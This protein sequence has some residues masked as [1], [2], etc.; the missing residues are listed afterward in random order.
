MS[1]E[2]QPDFNPKRRM[3]GPQF[4]AHTTSE[5]V[6]RVTYVEED[7]APTAAAPAPVEEAE[8]PPT[9]EVDEQPEQDQ[10][11]SARHRGGRRSSNDFLEGR[12]ASAPAPT[13]TT[14]WRVKANRWSGGLLKLSESTVE[15]QAQEDRR[16]IQRNFGGP[17]SVVTINTKGGVGKTSSTLMTAMTFGMIRGGGVVAWDNNETQGSLGHRGLEGSRDTTAR[18]LL[19]EIHRFADVETSRVGDLG[20]YLRSQG[21]AHFELLASDN[22]STVTGQISQQDVVD[23]RRL[24]ERFYKV[25]FIDTGNNLRA[26][27]WLEAVGGADHL[28]VPTAVRVDSAYGAV[29]T[30]ES[31]EEVLHTAGHDPDW[32][33]ANST[34]VI[35]LPRGGADQGLLR[36]VTEL[37]EGRCGSVHIAPYE[38]LMNPGDRIDYTRISDPTRAAW[39]KISAAIAARL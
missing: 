7:A 2:T 21:E 24:L 20:G 29:Q 37:M 12:R 15:R 22:R 5:A 34:A 31:I 13:A 17:K 3:S 27:N 16:T 36:D 28:L 14:G 32:I 6:G 9:A 35:S 38:P 8:A 11:L 25:L 1:E 33:R 39:L 30:L 19:Q 4:A 26:P 10:P 18:D 23:I